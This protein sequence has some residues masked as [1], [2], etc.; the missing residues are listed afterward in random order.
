MKYKV[1]DLVRINIRSYDK[2]NTNSISNRLLSIYA[3]FNGQ[4]ATIIKTYEN[5]QQY[6]IDL[7]NAEHMWFDEMFESIE[8]E[9]STHNPLSKKETSE[10]IV[11][12]KVVFYQIENVIISRIVQFPNQLESYIENYIKGVDTLLFSLYGAP[13]M[14]L[15]LC[16]EKVNPYYLAFKSSSSSKLNKVKFCISNSD[17]YAALQLNS[18]DQADLVL[19]GLK[20]LVCNFN[21]SRH[22]EEIEIDNEGIKLFGEIIQ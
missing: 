10:S 2:E 15:Y 11:D 17:A 13:T 8:D 20:Q 6:L 4:V 1:G 7:D 5:L 12:L 21:K 18:K 19:A 14:Q 9:N 16:K 22:K 3:K